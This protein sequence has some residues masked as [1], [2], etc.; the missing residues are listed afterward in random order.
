MWPRPFKK[1]WILFLF[2]S[3]VPVK[4]IHSF[5]ETEW[6]L[7]KEMLI[8]FFSPSSSCVCCDL[9]VSPSHWSFIWLCSQSP[10]KS[11]AL[12]IWSW[13][14]LY[15]VFGTEAG[16]SLKNDTKPGPCSSGSLC[17]HFLKLQGI[18]NTRSHNF[19]TP[20]RGLE[21]QSFSAA[22]LVWMSIK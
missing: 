17:W 5:K 18:S 15:C 14:H 21:F 22:V 16:L 9:H 12:R 1:Q 6:T 4:K 19:C 8:F 20:C 11:T 7:N 10:S 2:N 3:P 13:G